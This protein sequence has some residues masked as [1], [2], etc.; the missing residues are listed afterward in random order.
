[1]DKIH[2]PEM[3]KKADLVKV[4][5]ICNKVFKNKDCF[6]TSEEFKKVSKEKI[7]L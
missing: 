7:G 3:P 2:R 5:D 1:M 4:Y 6:Y